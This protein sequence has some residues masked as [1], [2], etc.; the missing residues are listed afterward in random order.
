[1]RIRRRGSVWGRSLE[2]PIRGVDHER[3]SEACA[4]VGKKKDIKQVEAI[5]R[6]FGMDDEQRRDFG[7]YVEDEKHQGRRGSKNDK[8]DFTH[9]ELRELAR[10]FIGQ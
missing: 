6:E 3:P 7:D 10:E 8:G 1:M 4:P 5:A 2:A 9:A